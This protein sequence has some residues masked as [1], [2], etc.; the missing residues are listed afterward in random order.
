MGVHHLLQQ[1]V[2][3]I[4]PAG[5]TRHRHHLAALGADRGGGLVQLIL[6][7]GGYHHLGPAAAVGLRDGPPYPAA[8]AGDEGHSVGEIEDVVGH[9]QSSEPGAPANP[10][11]WGW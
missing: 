5:V 6:L 10:D 3:V 9:L 4:L 2:D 8:A 7:A 11:S 1:R